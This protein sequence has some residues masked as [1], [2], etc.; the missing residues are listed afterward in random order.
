MTEFFWEA[1]L[2]GRKG[3]S[4]KKSLFLNAFNSKQ[5]LCHSGEFWT[6]SVVP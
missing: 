1:L 6:P 4:E 3:H 2:S 5:F